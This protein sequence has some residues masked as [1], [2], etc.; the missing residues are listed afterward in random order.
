MRAAR[1]SAL[2]G[3][4]VLTESALRLRLGR[5]RVAVLLRKDYLVVCTRPNV[6][7]DF[8]KLVT[9]FSACSLWEMMPREVFLPSLE[10]SFFC[11]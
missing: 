8:R 5:V 1:S 7:G 10:N 3:L 6:V 4:C 11:V 2:A 9:A